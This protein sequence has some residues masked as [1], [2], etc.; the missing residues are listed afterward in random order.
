MS[1]CSEYEYVFL[2][3]DFNAQTANLQDF[4]CSDTLLDKHLNLDN[5]TQEYFDQEAFLQN[6]NIPVNRVSNDKKTNNTG[7]KLVDICKNNNLL[8]LNG[9]FSLGAEKG[10]FT[11]WTNL[12]STAQ[13]HL[14]K[15]SK[16]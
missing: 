4:T 11:F 12:S 7:Y 13:F 16:Y 1:F 14:T 3:G 5:E 8:I 9:R 2:T 15:I 10:K 6:N